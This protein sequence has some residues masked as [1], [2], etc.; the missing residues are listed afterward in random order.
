MEVGFIV[1]HVGRDNVSRK[2]I[3]ATCDVAEGLGADALW[4]GDHIV[5]DCERST[6]AVLEHGA[7]GTGDP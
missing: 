2:S 1:P 6:S 3:D 4:F 5:Q 7:T